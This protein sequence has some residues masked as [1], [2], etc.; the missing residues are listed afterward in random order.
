[1]ILSQVILDSSE[2]E[3][4]L[5]HQ[6]LIVWQLIL[7]EATLPVV[8]FMANM[9]KSFPETNEAESIDSTFFIP[10]AG[11][12]HHAPCSRGIRSGQINDTEV[13]TMPYGT[14][15]WFNTKTGSGF[16]RTDD[17]ENV[18]FLNGAIQNSDTSS[19]HKGARVCLDVLKSKYGFT[20]I[21]VKTAELP[22]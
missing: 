3:V 15:R 8:A 21:N 5:W 18:L 19:I 20:A 1:L 6:G 14:V 7:I 11:Q 9:M 16:I 17:G 12:N 10:D 2:V 4:G 13:R 22:E